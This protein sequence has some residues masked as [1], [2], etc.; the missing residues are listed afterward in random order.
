MAFGL[1]SLVGAI[2]LGLL[3]KKMSD[4][5]IL[6]K[7][8]NPKESSSM[9]YFSCWAVVVTAAILTGCGGASPGRGDLKK[10]PATVVTLSVTTITA[11]AQAN[12]LIRLTGPAQCDVRV[13]A[14]DYH[15][16]GVRD[17]MS[18]STGVML[19][20]QGDAPACQ[21]PFPL[22]T[23]ARGTEMNKS[24]TLADPTDSETALLTAVYA[25]HG[26]AVV[27]PDYLGYAGSSYGFHPYLHADSQATTLVDAIRAAR[28]AAGKLGIS[29]S[30]KVMLSG[31]SQGGH[32]SMSAHRAIERQHA[33]EIKVAGGAHL[34]GPYNLS[35]ALS[36]P[37][38]FVG[39]QFFVPLLVTSWQKIYGDLYSNVASVFQPPYAGSIE[40]LLPNP[41]LTKDTLLT[42][43][44]LPG[45]RG[46][47]PNQVRDALFVPAF[48]RDV[49]TNA[50]NPLMQSAR[51]NDLL[52][53]NPIAPTL[54][55]SGSG[56]P[57]VLPS[58]HQ[59]T[60][61]AD[62]QSRGVTTVKSVDVDPQIRTMFGSPPQDPAEAAQYFGRYHGTLAPPICAAV[63]KC[64]F[65]QIKT[66]LSNACRPS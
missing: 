6:V 17:E 53:W 1:G 56:D 4:L 2:H 39:Y 64:F 66:G 15:T 28:H 43:G 14:L 24:R 27:A 3:M 23:Y 13:I 31:Y 47:S 33:G 46:E 52:G 51:R 37:D 25:A 11:G 57:T 42:E 5:C 35:A 38:A 18:N 9:K 41:T 55:C 65:D 62:F 48:I 60:L 45:F 26:Y 61:M 19:V 30:S 21:G 36:H 16:V 7:I 12:G 59:K 50:Q 20:P 10:D 32:A 34:S 63:A 29:L 49:Q 44:R 8:F 54:L 58:L 40:D 22:L